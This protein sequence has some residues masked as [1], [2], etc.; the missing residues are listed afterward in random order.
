VNATYPALPLGEREAA[1]IEGL[2]N[3]AAAVL[4]YQTII[5]AMKSSRQPSV[6]ARSARSVE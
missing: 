6:S 1:V 4:A 3:P 5:A 2:K